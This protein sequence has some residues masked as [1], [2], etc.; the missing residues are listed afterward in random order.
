MQVIYKYL[1]L[2]FYRQS[3]LSARILPGYSACSVLIVQIVYYMKRK[4][5]LPHA[6][7]YASIIFGFIFSAC[8]SSKIV[9]SSKLKLMNDFC[10]PAAPYNYDTS[11]FLY[12]DTDSLLRNETLLSSILSEQDILMA[13]ATGTLS[14]IRNMLG[15]SMDSTV[16]GQLVYFRVNEQIQRSLLLFRT[17]I[18]AI[19]AELDCE[20]RRLK[21]FSSYLENINDKRNKKL[22][23][24]AILAG[25]VSTIAPVIVTKKTP[26]N[27]IIISSGIISAGFGVLTLNPHGKK[28]KLVQFRNLLEDIWFA[29]KKSNIYPPDIWYALN[30]PKLSNTR[31]FSKVQVVRMRWMKF[32]LNNAIDSSL[33]NLLFREGGVYNED[34]LNLRIIM[35]SE[36]QSAIKSI[37]QDLVNFIINL[38]KIS[39]RSMLSKD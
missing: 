7:F 35:L 5:K 27:T 30:E 12:W 10:T 14:F 24:G 19:S 2:H 29:P 6:L 16:R 26:Q 9:S 8:G 31:R 11:F 4:F 28:L 17:E 18:D 13:N 38:N 1:L 22:T 20:E 3:A 32:E 33:E 34:N 37:N 15:S 39:R 36:L 23:V 25:A 21:Q